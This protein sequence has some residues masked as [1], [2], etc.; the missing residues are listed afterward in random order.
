M[1]HVDVVVVGGGVS[2]LTAAHGLIE[3]GFTVAL[4]EARDRLG[5]RIATTRQ[6]DSIVPLELGAEFVHGMPPEIFSLPA[7]DFTLYEIHGE[8]WTSQHGH[9]RQDH[10]LGGLRERGLAEIAAWRGED[11]SLAS[12][13]D[14]R[15]PEGRQAAARRLIQDYVEGFDAADVHSVSIKWLDQ[16]EQAARSIEGGRQFRLSSGYGR[17]IAWLRD[18]LPADRALVRLNTIVHEVQWSPGQVLIGSHAPSG[19]L[20]EPVTA[21]TAVITLPLGVLT[22]APHEVGAVRFVPEPREKQPTYKDLGMGQVLK[23]LL[24][25]HE[26]FWDRRRPPFPYL[27]RMSF[28][29]T[30][31]ETFPTWWT[32]YPLVAPL[33]TA[34]VAGPRAV[35]LANQA[36][37]RIVEQ[38]VESLARSL[39][40]PT[41]ALEAELESG[42]L[43]NWNTDPF[44]RGAYSHVRVGGLE[45]PRR[46]GAPLAAT[47]FF[48]GEA[49]VSDGHTGTVH[50]AMASGNR[51]VGE[52]LRSR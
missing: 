5:G 12:F 32:S 28:L 52:I 46:L 10:D 9:P 44:A 21:Q 48:A 34:W 33:L 19:A 49:T 4:L 47:L 17:L 6:A 35:P 51:V 40:V 20:L 2:G 29:F 16:T 25:F 22:A 45:A 30:P 8:T 23:V 24:R 31:E 15:F 27:P 43:H 1:V 14:E 18:G 50:G 11:R 42:H 3:H 38:A 36:D 13:L 37:A 7:S 26:A 41:Q 39:G